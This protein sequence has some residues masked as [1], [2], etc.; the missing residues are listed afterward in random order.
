MK[1]RMAKRLLAGMMAALM[2]FGDASGVLASGLPETEVV[3]STENVDETETVEVSEVIENTE[4][5]ESSEVPL[6]I[7]PKE[8][9]EV[10]EEFEPEV[11]ADEVLLAETSE[12]T[13]PIYKVYY[14]L[15]SVLTPKMAES[16]YN[17]SKWQGDKIISF[18]VNTGA[19]SESHNT[20]TWRI[21]DPVA[22]LLVS[23]EIFL[24]E[25]DLWAFDSS[26]DN[27]Y[28]DNI[29]AILANYAKSEVANEETKFSDI[30][31][32]AVSEIRLLTVD[33][34]TNPAYGYY[35]TTEHDNNKAM[36]AGNESE[37]Y[38]V[39]SG[40]D[41]N[42]IWVL[43]DG[44]V[45]NY[46]YLNR[47]AD[48]MSAD[49]EEVQQEKD[50]Q[51]FL[52]ETYR[53]GYVAAIELNLDR[54]FMTVYNDFNGRWND[55]DISEETNR[56]W[57]LLLHSDDSGFAAE[58][59]SE[60]PFGGDIVVNVTN[61]GNGTYDK[62]SI[63]VSDA[64]GKIVWYD[65]ATKAAQ[66]GEFLFI[67]DVMD[68]PFV[69]G[70]YT[71]KVFAENSEEGYVSNVLSSNLKIVSAS[72]T[73]LQISQAYGRVS[74]TWD[75]EN[76]NGW[77]TYCDV[78]R[79]DSIDGT[80]TK[81]NTETISCN[82][83]NGY[84]FY[85]DIVTPA[86][87]EVT[88]PTYYYKVAVVDSMTGD[89]LGEMSEP[90]TNANLYY[91]DQEHEGY[92]GAYL[93]DKDK[94]KLTSL[95]L[96]EG[97]AMEL[98]VAFVKE[99]GNVEY[100]ET[101]DLD[102]VRWYL[103]TGYATS[104]EYDNEEIEVSKD[105]LGIYPAMVTTTADGY[106][107]L[108]S[109][110]VYL[111][112]E[113]GAT[114][115]YYLTAEIHQ[116]WQFERY[117]QIPITVEEAEEGADYNQRP[118]IEFT[119]TQAE[120]AQKLRDLMVARDYDSYFIAQDGAELSA[121]MDFYDTYAEREGM[122]PYEG[123]YL[124]YQAGERN[125]VSSIYSKYET[126]SVSFNGEYYS[127]YKMTT[128]FITTAEEEAQVNAKIN[129]L[130][131]TPGGALYNAAY[132]DTT[133][134]QKIKAIYD[135]IIA[136]VNPS[137][138]GDRTKPIY[139]T[140]WHT[141]FGAYGGYP[142]SGTCGAFAVLFTRL[143]REMGIPSKVIMGTDSAAHAYNIVEV[144][145]NWYFIDTNSRRW[146]AD[147][148]NFT[149]AQ[150]QYFYLDSSFIA[151]YLSKVP[152]NDYYVESIGVAVVTGTDGSVSNGTT[153]E[154][155]KKGGY[156]EL[157]RAV[158]YI[159]EQASKEGNENVE[160][161]LTISDG[162]MAFPERSMVFAGEQDEYGGWI[163]YDD[164]VTIDLGGN[165]L[166]IR[167]G[168]GV[169]IAAKKVHNGVISIGDDAVLE[170]RNN[171]DKADSV[172][173]NLRIIYKSTQGAVDKTPIFEIF[174]GFENKV[175]LKDSVTLDEFYIVELRN[176]IELNTD[177]SVK[178]GYIQMFDG[179]T[180]TDDKITINGTLTVDGA[181]YV[182]AGTYEIEEFISKRETTF[183]APA[184]TKFIIGDK[185]TL[186]D[187]TV[188]ASDVGIWGEPGTVEVALKRY[189]A[190]AEDTVP[191]K[192]ATVDWSGNIF[193]Y[194][195]D[196]V[197]APMIHFIAQDYVD[198]VLQENKTLPSGT[199]IGTVTAKGWNKSTGYY[200]VALTN[201]NLAQYITAEIPVSGKTFTDITDGV[202]SVASLS[203][204]VT[205]TS[206][207]KSKVFTSLKNAISG[208]ASVANSTAGTYVFMFA[209][210]AMLSEDIT[211]PA[212][213]KN[214]E[215]TA[216]EDADVLLNFGGN[217]LT[218]SGTVTL[219]PS[220]KIS[221]AAEIRAKQIIFQGG[222]WEIENITTDSLELEGALS[223]DT[224]AVKNRV[225]LAT[226]AAISIRE[227]GILNGVELEATEKSDEN[228]LLM[229]QADTKLSLNGSL[230]SAN[231]NT[232]L[233]FAIL[234]GEN[235]TDMQEKQKLFVT[236]ME[237][238]PVERIQLKQASDAPLYQVLVQKSDSIYVIGPDTF[239][240]EGAV[241]SYVDESG[242]TV[243]DT[244]ADLGAAIAEINRLQVK[245]AYTITVYDDFAVAGA[246]ALPN[247]AYISAL[248][249]VG[250]GIE[251][252][253]K[254]GSNGKVALT[255]DTTL[256]NLK[257]ENATY[258]VTI[259]D[260]SLTI[261]A[262]VE[263]P[264]KVALNSGKKGS[265]VVP[266]EGMLSNAT[267]VNV[268]S[269]VNDGEVT[270]DTIKVT[271][272]YLNNG[273]LYANQMLQITNL[274]LDGKAV[275]KSEKDFK[276]TGM[277]YSKTSEAAL[278]SRQNAKKVPYLNITG[279]VSLDSPEDKI[280][281]GV[282][283]VAG[284]VAT[285]LDSGSMLL[286]VKTATADM[287]APVAE[288]AGGVAA[289][290]AENGYFLQKN[291][292]GIYVYYASDVAAALYKKDDLNEEVLH[293]YFV[294]FAN[295]VSE[296]EA[297]KD[298][299]VEYRIALLADVNSGTN[300]ATVALPTKAAKVTIT[301]DGGHIY[302]IFY[303]GNMTL[304]TPT[305]FEE[306]CF[307]P[308][309]KSK[310]GVAST[311]TAGK[312]D[313]TLKDVEVG[314]VPGM[315]IKD[316]TGSKT[317][318]TT[319]DADGFVVTG[320]ISGSKKL[321]I[322]KPVTVKGSV[323]V[324]DLV[325]QGGVRLDVAGAM[326]VTDIYSDKNTAIAEPQVNAIYYG[327]G[328]NG[329]SNLTV[330]GAIKGN[331][332]V[333][334]ELHYKVGDVEKTEYQPVMQS[335][336]FILNNKLALAN[337][338]KAA[339]S[340]VKFFLGAVELGDTDV[341]KANKSVY[342]VDAKT[343]PNV[344][345]V[346]SIR[347]GVE[348]S[349]YCLDFTQ[350]INEINNVGDEETVFVIEICP[351]TNDANINLT[352]T[353]ITDA[354]AVSAITMPKKGK[355]ASV[356]II[357]KEG[358]SITYSGNIAYPGV[359]EIS[360]V[361]L[362]SSGSC[363]ISGTK[364][365]S[366]VRLSNTNAV[367]KDIKNVQ[368]LVLDD[369]T[370]KT[371]GAVAVTEVIMFGRTKW[372]A[373]DKTTVT[374][375][376]VSAVEA[377]SYIGVKQTAKTWVP[378]F[379][380]NGSVCLNEAGTPVAIKL[381]QPTATMENPVEI[382]GGYKNVSLVIAPKESADRFVAWPFTKENIANNTEGITTENLVAY[383]TV[384]N[385]ALNGDKAEMVIRIVKQQGSQDVAET[386]AK[387][388]DEAVTIINNIGDNAGRYRLELLQGSTENPLLT[389]K[390]GTLIGKMTLP[391]KAAEVM[392]KGAN[393]NDTVALAY[394][395]ALAVNC[396][397]IFDNVI[398]LQENMT[399]NVSVSYGGAYGLTFTGNVAAE[400]GDAVLTIT[401]VKAAKGTLTLDGAEVYVPGAISV[402]ELAVIGESS[403]K[404]D[405]KI[406]IT[407]ISGDNN[408]ALLLEHY[409]TTKN[410]T[411]LTVN[412]NISNVALKLVP[413]LYDKETENYQAATVESVVGKQLAAMPKASMNSIA[414]GY[415]NEDGDFVSL[416]GGSLYKQNA[417]LYYTTDALSLEVVAE[418]ASG[419]EAPQIYRSS[420]TGWDYAVKEIDKR[421]DS[422]LVYR[423][424]LKEDIGKNEL[425]KT[426]TLPAKAKEVT[427]TSE[428]G[429]ENNVYFTG[430]KITL[431][432]NTTF[433]N[434]GLFAVKKVTT[435]NGSAYVPV[436]YSVSAG[437]FD[438][439]WKDLTYQTPEQV[440]RQVG[441]ISGG[442]KNTFTVLLGSESKNNIFVAEKI[443]NFGTVNI[444]NEVQSDMILENQIENSGLVTKGMSGIGN[445][446]LYPGTMISC[447]A[448]SVSVK[449][450]MIRGSILCA[451]D[452][453]VSQTVMLE[454][455]ILEA[456]SETI[457]D[458]KLSLGNVVVEDTKNYLE[459]KVSNKGKSLLSISG[460][461]T[462][463]PYY[464][465]AEAESAITVALL[466]A[467]GSAYVQLSEGMDVINAAKA[468]VFWFV[469]KYTYDEAEQPVEGMGAYKT[470][471]GF[472][473]AAKT[474]KY[475]TIGR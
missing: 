201:D 174:A 191:Y 154:D 457:G 429:E 8:E 132:G 85:T 322:A 377:G 12:Y 220:L 462:A 170:L 423:M 373:F 324:T 337:M 273:H 102:G 444:Y 82:N 286:N 466:L 441:S 18:G 385:E 51:S 163:C 62:I 467:D 432:T 426:L 447:D 107:E 445:L 130:I 140:V 226:G 310:K 45:K 42:Q 67:T 316:I 90:A 387:S 41:N 325:L 241:L 365:V 408:A 83:S 247:K 171:A 281:I 345:W 91:G 217:K 435:E 364:N 349:S 254:I 76:T 339:L 159:V 323:K 338:P 256:S 55:Y 378:M 353:N 366:E 111:Q 301:S 10:I 265:L 23:N 203:V 197:T 133:T 403:L 275:V 43:R 207:G 143:S 20:N 463:S 185:L 19:V 119:T 319:L 233:A 208:L 418:D 74:V 80:Y 158:D 357:S 31:Q 410:A 4:T 131:H 136:N 458:G 314:I 308:M 146:L 424:V 369:V 216:A 127:G 344:V 298:S 230:T 75:L 282:Y 209:E 370:L 229:I 187:F 374:D 291:K 81:V 354:K 400:K 25:D 222:N 334:L 232:K 411:Q 279:T 110:Q 415:L 218:T 258:T 406:A 183:H 367:F 460:T 144:G 139:H 382:T 190:T 238:F 28:P 109:Y 335:G 360:N 355:A 307:N 414:L 46:G 361:V 151:N 205:E 176:T 142:G 5:T 249:I 346:Q 95:T 182:Y 145:N 69:V 295:A 329:I 413:F 58:V 63:V 202:L 305:V 224:L 206:T 390:N 397:T 336:K 304:K 250:D 57:K 24:K 21:L 272:A 87:G 251:G 198:G 347:D 92:I 155:L 231:E 175:I 192:Q 393:A 36:S 7:A 293:G 470:G 474:I 368:S 138:A 167:D 297:L 362:A 379:T 453:T 16:P 188:W 277:L 315:A 210:N 428:A 380:V 30:E 39:D 77:Y 330:N 189:F 300:P 70:N 180:E 252:S 108:P 471:Y 356:S 22:G 331:N 341:V 156:T 161:T 68:S 381:Y 196:F 33:E 473:K 253:A 118:D 255:S 123:D 419:N 475:G 317:Q 215:L 333:D 168:L 104:D 88:N 449:N 455:A 101:E 289:Y 439:T 294:S 97:E 468:D 296:I 246:L 405:G 211:L 195:V 165:S 124:F 391:S 44:S 98:G 221:D 40:E 454:S 99:D 292:T 86:A 89:V 60:I 94:N 150:E 376:D 199:T 240:G 178:G 234:S 280:Q 285:K 48:D 121:Y 122:K 359:L 125:S 160:Y 313:L 223:I 1:N 113:D 394:K 53:R 287:F 244:F 105:K 172:Y 116:G 29:N 332:D 270:A 402:K 386:Y 17:N 412:G 284:D 438:L 237:E 72:A 352:D 348:T 327:K 311:F 446:N 117:W 371:T 54:V 181:C 100:L 38:L 27:N 166:I 157:S 443:S 242:R 186:A 268:A 320:N 375:V 431:K 464:N 227:A 78:Y 451:K 120:S 404:A 79:S 299:T 433:D 288:N 137:V 245:R 32:A 126:F 13:G 417:G 152:G 6:P 129:A 401:S 372:D 177:L 61:L 260:Y 459:A 436:T 409:F 398:L 52:S 422:S 340:E 162:N 47:N 56:A 450:A 114:G 96:H 134:E 309:D 351:L 306:V 11:Q 212:Y 267:T 263:F 465:G 262:R 9:R 343:N 35:N 452:I 59:P 407:N 363:S 204:R 328:S 135:W 434:V 269:L 261:G 461:V 383:K 283:G 219:S 472:Y 193:N 456:G 173:E 65:T 148:D 243:A 213:V 437:K 15:P 71:M 73:N 257:F 266:E 321:V 149:R 389:T 200:N 164:R 421:A 225:L 318:T 342:V 290:P 388:F 303:T 228:P 396:D 214:A 384:K 425:I 194:G 427:I 153:E 128:P 326:A 259:G 50:Y 248:T 84:G 395:G 278:Y 271:D 302:D 2:L 469:P 448:G 392:I 350:A 49:P 26:F 14:G 416:T 169:S 64:D 112:A 236:D 103:H 93:V 276:I 239:V 179:N 358:E 66:T 442:G 312:Y 235:F 106:L 264:N 115:T 184:K 440:R 3:E 420:F 399:D 147:E 141:L 34:V 430:T 37:S 274:T